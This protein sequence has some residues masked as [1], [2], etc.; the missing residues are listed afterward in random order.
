M[1][2][3]DEN[4]VKRERREVAK[5]GVRRAQSAID[6]L[7]KECNGMGVAA[8]LP[9]LKAVLADNSID[10]PTPDLLAEMATT[11]STGESIELE[12]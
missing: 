3:F 5:E 6:Q 10:I 11:L 12:P 2:F 7:A 9:K 1:S 4:E 8:I